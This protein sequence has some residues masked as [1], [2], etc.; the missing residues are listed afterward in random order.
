MLNLQSCPLCFST[1]FDLYIQTQDYFLTQE[2][3]EIVKCKHCGL[4][5]THPKPLLNNMPAYY[6]SDEYI[7]HNTRKLNIKTIL[8]KWARKIS[9]SNKIQI[10]KKF[11]PDN[12][13]SNKLL[14]IGC[15]TGYFLKHAQKNGFE[16]TG[17][18][19]IDEA[20][21]QAVNANPNISI[22]SR[23]EFYKYPKQFNVIT[24][25]H[26][27][28]HLYALTDD[29]QRIADLLTKNGLLV[30]AVPNYKSY[31]AQYY[32]SYWAA[33]DV[34]RHLYHFCENDIV[35]LA[36]KYGFTHLQTLPMK[37]D[38]YYVSMLSEKYKNTP[39]LKAIYNSLRI[40]Y[41]SNKKA[42]NKSNNYGYSS[43]IYVLKKSH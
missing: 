1:N 10:I 20:R 26:V 2:K 27:L 30:I 35:N 17:Y 13:T 11:I 31:D 40:G 32:G 15:G 23:E 24:L 8:Y 34:P 9:V 19:P 33:Y 41:D 36:R 4:L 28:E 29:L 25:W 14:D 7:S 43:Q 12:F 18:E 3:F 22:Y 42:S 6:Q 38:A 5:L 16:C 21:Q 39:T 37:L